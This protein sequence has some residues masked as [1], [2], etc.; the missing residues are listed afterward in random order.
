MSAGY[1]LSWTKKAIADL[2]DL[3][4]Y[5]SKHFGEKEVGVFFQKLNARI[6]LISIN[7]LLFPESK[8]KTGLR[9]CVVTKFTVVYYQLRSS[10]ITIVAILDSRRNALFVRER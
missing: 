5:L 10:K 2:D 1:E 9:K 3:N 4:F 7:P 6:Q 8:I